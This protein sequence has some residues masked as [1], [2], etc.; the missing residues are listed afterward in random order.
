MKGK[1]ADKDFVAEFIMNCAQKG[2]FDLDNIL[3]AATKEVEE[4]DSTIRNIELLKKKRSKLLDV[5]DSFKKNNKAPNAEKLILSFYQVK[6]LQLAKVICEALEAGQ[7]LSRLYDRRWD[8]ACWNQHEVQ[9]TVK[10]L[11]EI[12][13][14]MNKDK[15]IASAPNFKAFQNFVTKK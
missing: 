1:K 9:L 6:N 14:L 7:E 8:D 11:C 15:V 10:E 3:A 5:L 12:K 2:L 4:I 13:V